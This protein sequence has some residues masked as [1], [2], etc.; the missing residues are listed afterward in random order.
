VESHGETNYAWNGDISLAYQVVGEG[1]LDLLYLQGYASHVD[2]NWEGPALRRFLHGLARYARL[3]VTDRR[4]WGA[5][6][7]SRRLMSHPWRR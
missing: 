4:G 1:H 5:L 7:G 3:I 6:I 2:L